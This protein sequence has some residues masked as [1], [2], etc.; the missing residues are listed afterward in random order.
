MEYRIVELKNGKY[1]PQV[2][3]DAFTKY[4][5]TPI[6]IDKLNNY[7]ATLNIEVCK[8]IYDKPQKSKLV[9]EFKTVKQAKDVCVKHKNQ[10]SICT[11][12]V[13]ETFNL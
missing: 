3:I 6:Y 8:S 1:Q 7:K 4:R 10:I 12:T 5:F 11:N 13:V 9:C 2:L